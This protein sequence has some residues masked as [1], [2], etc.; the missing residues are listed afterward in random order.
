MKQI[1]GIR[2]MNAEKMRDF[3]ISFYSGKHLCE[4]C[5]YK[6]ECQANCTNGVKAWLESEVEE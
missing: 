6:N 1:D 3:I 2:N 5:I 4:C